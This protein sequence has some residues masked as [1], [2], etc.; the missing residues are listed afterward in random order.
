[1]ALSEG[2]TGKGKK[3]AKIVE[4]LAE[5][6]NATSNATANATGAD[7]AMVSNTRRLV[8]HAAGRQAHFDQMPSVKSRGGPRRLYKGLELLG[9]DPQLSSAQ[10]A[11]MAGISTQEVN[12]LKELVEH[13][14]EDMV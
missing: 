2:L 14:K 6:S 11:N 7:A 3:V 10:I 5:H 8:R 4:Y 12:A 13:A 9:D 1:M